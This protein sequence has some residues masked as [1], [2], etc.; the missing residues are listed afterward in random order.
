M[1]TKGERYRQTIAKSDFV[2]RVSLV[3]LGLLRKSRNQKKFFNASLL[4]RCCSTMTNDHAV[5]VGERFYN[6]MMF[7]TL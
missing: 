1:T 7:L 2:C 4:E 6:L 3:G 5:T